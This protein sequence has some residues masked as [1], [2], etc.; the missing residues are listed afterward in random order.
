MLRNQ[1]RLVRCAAA[2]ALASGLASTTLGADAHYRVVARTG[3]A[4]PGGGQFAILGVPVISPGGRVAFKGT[5]SGVFAPTGLWSEGV[6]GMN[7]LQLAARQGN[8]IPGV[9]NTHIGSL[10]PGAGLPIMNAVGEVA[11]GLEIVGDQAAFGDYAILTHGAGG[12]DAVAAPGQLISLPCAGFGCQR[13]L[14]DIDPYNFAFNAAG[15]VALHAAIAGAGVNGDNDQLVLRADS[16]GLQA[17][18]REGD[19]PPGTFGVEYSGSSQNQPHLNDNGEALI[20]NHLIDPVAP[21]SFWSVSRG[22][23]G[24]MSI[25]AA[26]TWTTPMGGEFG[27]GWFGGGLMGFNSAGDALFVQSAYFAEDDQRTG[28]WLESDGAIEAIC[29]D[30]MPAPGGFEYVEPDGFTGEINTHGDILFLALIQGPGVTFDSDSVLVRRD[31]DDDSTMIV[32]EGAQVPGFLAG[33]HYTSIG[34]DGS[35][36]LSDGRVAYTGTLNGPG[37]HAGN[38][39]GLWITRPNA[40]PALLMREGQAMVIGGQLRNVEFFAALL[41]HGAESGYEIGLSQLGQVAMLVTF[42]DGTQ[43]VIVASPRAACPGDVNGDGAVDFLDLNTVLSAF[44]T[45][46]DVVPGDL[47]LDGDVDF[48][49]L[50]M[51]LNSFNESCDFGP[52]AR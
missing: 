35:A 15:Q 21:A 17:L 12:L 5:L 14:T 4:A 49:D 3:Q 32:R 11:F 27:G 7:N 44:N 2:L 28:L 52:V 34:W 24:D 39:L 23:P 30:G 31:A 50:N 6:A 45:S 46:G 26:Q 8:P 20:R 29:F 33:V 19:A 36:L 41:G 18:L 43:A 1:H 25:V 47:D 51:V 37:I 38:D 22:V 9:A 48:A 42:T 10:H 13:W 16:G 40:T